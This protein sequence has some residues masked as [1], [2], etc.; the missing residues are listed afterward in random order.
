MFTQRDRKDEDWGQWV[1]V[2]KN[3]DLPHPSGALPKVMD[4]LSNPADDEPDVPEKKDEDDAASRIWYAVSGSQN[5]RK[6]AEWIKYQTDLVLFAKATA[7]N[8]KIGDSLPV[9][10]AAAPKNKHAPEKASTDT[11]SRKLLVEVRLPL[12]T[13]E[14]ADPADLVAKESTEAFCF[15]LQRIANFMELGEDPQKLI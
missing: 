11:V 10:A 3:R 6:L 7:A 8:N 14:P 15:Q 13:S 5:V 1:V 2:E 4:D 12:R 9:V